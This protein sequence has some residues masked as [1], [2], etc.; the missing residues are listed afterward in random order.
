MSKTSK[1]PSDI[2]KKEADLRVAYNALP[3]NVVDEMPPTLI[4]RITP[5]NAWDKERE[6]TLLFSD[7]EK[8]VDKSGKDL[9]N[10]K[11]LEDRQISDESFLA[12]NYPQY[13]NYKDSGKEQINLNESS[14]NT[15]QNLKALE[16]VRASLLVDLN[17]A[18]D[19]SIK[20]AISHQISNIIKCIEDLNKTNTTTSFKNESYLEFIDISSEEYRIYEFNNGKTVMIS[21]PLKLNIAKSGGHRIYDNSGVS[22][23]IPQGW[24]HL[25]WRSK[26]GQPNFVK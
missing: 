13:N 8:Y 3:T 20:V 7:K 18:K 21:E 19:Y 14:S 1:N 15:N 9:F 22:H 26:S 25:S 17:A 10:L 11:G 23:Y 6:E 12:T 4:K 2:A 16:Q 24:C 5:S